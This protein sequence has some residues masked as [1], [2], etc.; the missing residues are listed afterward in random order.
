MTV[1]GL[2]LLWVCCLT[3]AW[4]MASYQIVSCIQ[5]SCSPIVKCSKLTGDLT[6]VNNFRAIA[7]S[8]SMSKLLE[9][10]LSNFV[11]TDHEQESLANAKVSA[12]DQCVPEG[13]WRR[14]LWQIKARNMMLKSTFSSC[15]LPNLR[16]PAKCSKNSNFPSS[17][18][19]KVID[20]GA[21]RKLI[22][23]FLLVSNYGRIYYRFRDIDAFSSKLAWFSHPIL[24]WRP[25]AEERHAL[26]T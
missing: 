16:N 17:M 12:R 24:V 5:L 22:C 9:T 18:S 4:N 7:V 11:E 1:T 26:S 25:L 13:H 2:M 14:N 6:D 15:C 21:N 10:I 3:Y 19:S 20:L 8:H 23:N